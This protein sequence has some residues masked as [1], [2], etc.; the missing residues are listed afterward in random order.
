MITLWLD[1]Q[2]P[3]ALARWL[4]TEFD[5]RATH[6]SELGLPDILDQTIWDAA[7]ESGAIIVSKDR[8]FA[9][10]AGTVQRTTPVLWLRCG[11]T[12]NARLREVLKRTLGEALE[13]IASGEVV[14]E[15][16]DPEYPASG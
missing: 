11:N 8:D 13:L 10:F 15:I 5:V 12:S 3:P 14:V 1:N 4:T 2:L 16:V 6:V 7:V 9:Q